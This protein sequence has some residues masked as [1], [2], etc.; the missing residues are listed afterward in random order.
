ME[1]HPAPPGHGTHP[2]AAAPVPGVSSSARY[3][4][5]MHPEI[6]QTG[7]GTCPKC[8]MALEPM[9]EFAEVEADPEYDSMR[10]RFLG[11]GGLPLPWLFVSCLCGNSGFYVSPG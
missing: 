3:T 8:G 4:C 2:Q 9:D 7:P 11:R 5:P 10:R 6:V 1:Q